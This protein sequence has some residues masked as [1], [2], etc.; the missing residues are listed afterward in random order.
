MKRRVMDIYFMNDNPFNVRQVIGNS[1]DS[2][3]Q[4]K[5]A[6]CLLV[7]KQRLQT[8]VEERSKMRLLINKLSGGHRNPSYAQYYSI[9]ILIDQ[10]IWELCLEFDLHMEEMSLDLQ[11]DARKS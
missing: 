1:E 6:K 10:F 2:T 11:M 7:A 8:L 9:L 4:F 3:P 5:S